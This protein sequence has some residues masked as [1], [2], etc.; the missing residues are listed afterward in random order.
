MLRDGRS[1]LTRFSDPSRQSYYFG[2]ENELANFYKRASVHRQRL[3][4]IHRGE[5]LYRG[6]N[7]KHVAI[8]IRN[9]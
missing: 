2:R 6:F 7:D 5:G 8:H 9:Q 3:Q 1:L 4:G